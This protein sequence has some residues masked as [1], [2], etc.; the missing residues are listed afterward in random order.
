MERRMPELYFDIRDILK[1]PR[2]AWSLKKMQVAVRG[3]A[4]SWLIYLI[5]TY[6]SLLLTETGRSAGIPTLFRYFEFFP[7]LL[8]SF[9]AS[10]QFILYGAGC[11]LALFNLL[12]TVTALA[13]ITFE[14]VRGN[15]IFQAS[16]ALR[17]AR[18]H[19]STVVISV[20]ILFAISCAAPAT[21]IVW[22]LIGRIPVAGPVLFGISGIPLFFW[23]LFGIIMCLVGIAGFHLVP[24]IAAS[25]GEDVLETLIQCFSTVFSRPCRLVV[26][27]I[28]AHAVVAAVTIILAAVS[29]KAMLGAAFL[30]GQFF[31][32]SF[33]ELFTIALY[34]IPG[35][36]DFTL[37]T[38]GLYDYVPVLHPP[39]LTPTASTCLSV[40]IAGWLTGLS[41]LLVLLWVLSYGLNCFSASQ[42]LT[43]LGI[44]KHR[45]GVDLRLKRDTS[46]FVPE[47]PPE[48]DDTQG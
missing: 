7:Y 13:R 39:Y 15:D 35:A 37:Y 31:G 8:P 16:E 46:Y 27:E 23:G 4:V 26:Y 24:A 5:I 9:G 38:Q 45:D 14:D 29:I 12:S 25:L 47:T 19:R 40:R 3:I 32:G 44:R 6:L 1:V 36:V 20:S 2:L 48:M 41:G 30:C 28:T 10:W 18:V 43:Y 22:G 34:R 33:D 42:L 17:Y 11:I 21:M